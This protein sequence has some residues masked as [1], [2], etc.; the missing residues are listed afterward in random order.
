MDLKVTG[1][2][3]S[4][5]EVQGAARS[6]SPSPCSALSCPLT[7]LCLPPPCC[8]PTWSWLAKAMHLSFLRSWV[9]LFSPCTEECDPGHQSL[10]IA[11]GRRGAVHN[12]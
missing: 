10:C 3:A 2:E 9:P 8:T 12:A 5:A 6:L 1:E 7:D 11:V 4:A